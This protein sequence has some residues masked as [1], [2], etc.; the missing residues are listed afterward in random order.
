SSAGSVQI[1]VLIDNDFQL[2]VDGTAYTNGFVVH[3]GCADVS[4]PA[5][6][7]ISN[8]S[9]GNHV[10]AVQAR[11]RGNVAFFDVSLSLPR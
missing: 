2:F 4:P 9:A 8:L 7:T 3:E 1:S 10:L 11:D 5:P 6:I